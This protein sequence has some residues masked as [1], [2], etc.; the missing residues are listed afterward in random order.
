MSEAFEPASELGNRVY[1]V[2]PDRDSV[3]DVLHAGRMLGHWIRMIDEYGN[4][5]W[6]RSAEHVVPRRWAV[7][8]PGTEDTSHMV[9]A[10]VVQSKLEH[11][12]PDVSVCRTAPEAIDE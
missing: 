5:V 7:C 10:S 8:Y 12:W 9:D 11:R 4:A 1:H 2:D 3:A 6:F